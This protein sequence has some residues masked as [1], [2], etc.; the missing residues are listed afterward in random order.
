[1]RLA[2]SIR[3]TGANSTARLF[4]PKQ[5]RLADSTHPTFLSC[6][7]R[8]YLQTC[9]HECRVTVEDALFLATLRPVRELKLLNLV[10][11]PDEPLS[12]PC[13]N[14]DH[15]LVMLFLAEPHAYPISRAI[16]CAVRDA[17]YDG[18]VY[19]SFFSMLRNGVQPFESYFGLSNRSI[20]ELRPMEAAK[21]IPNLA[22]FGRPIQEGKL[23]VSCI[24]RVILRKATYSIHFGPAGL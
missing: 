19:P 7:A 2:S 23:T 12:H 18:L 6:T 24:N 10:S 8:R 9:L 21:M 15:A 16:A 20:S 1:M 11:F 14:L 3:R 17:G 22:I 4:R 13:E 5:R